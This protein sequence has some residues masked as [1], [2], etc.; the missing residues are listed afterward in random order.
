MA[1]VISRG[2]LKPISAN[3]ASAGPDRYKE[4][5]YS[6]AIAP[7]GARKAPNKGLLLESLV[8]PQKQAVK[9]ANEASPAENSGHGA[10]A[11]SVIQDPASR[12][13]GGRADMLP[14]VGRS[15]NRIS[16]AEA[17]NVRAVIG[18]RMPYPT[19]RDVIVR[20]K[21]KNVM[22]EATMTAIGTVAAQIP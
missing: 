21:R 13:D 14:S 7:L 22:N 2:I 10:L 1:A 20:F 12:Q 15:T 17:N 6:A 5:R 8:R 11:T 4:N 3:S 16:A 19:R 9:S 18:I